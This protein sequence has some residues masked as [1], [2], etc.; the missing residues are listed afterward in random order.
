[1]GYPYPPNHIPSEQALVRP[2]NEVKEKSTSK[3]RQKEEIPKH[4]F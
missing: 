4:F 2:Q 3:V 1:M